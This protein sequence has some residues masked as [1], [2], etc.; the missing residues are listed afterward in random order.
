MYNAK[1]PNF[2]N[3]GKPI[4]VFKNEEDAREVLAVIETGVIALR[5]IIK[6]EGDFGPQNFDPK[7]EARKALESMGYSQS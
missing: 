1:G 2:L 3:R 4:A 5:R 7:K 6:G